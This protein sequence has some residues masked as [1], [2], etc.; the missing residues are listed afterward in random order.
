V[1]QSTY[2]C[3]FTKPI[4]VGKSII[5]L[6]RAGRKMRQMSYDYQ[7]DS[8]VSLDLTVFAEH[9][10]KDHDGAQQ[11]C[12]QQLPESAVYVRLG[13]GQI[14]VLTYEPDQ[15]VYAWTRFV[16]GGPDAFV[17]SIACVPE[18]SQFRLYM[19]VGRTINGS[20]VRTIEVLEPE[21][22][23]SSSTDR[24]EMYFFDNYT[25]FTTAPFTTS[26]TGLTLYAGCTVTVRVDDQI[27]H[28]QTV[29][30]DGT[31]TLPAVPSTR[32][33]IGFPYTSTLKTF[34]IE[35]PAQMGTG[36]GKVK[37]MTH[38]GVRLLDSIN[39]KHGS[40]LTN[41]V[42]ESFRLASDSVSAVPPMFSGDKRVAFE[43]GFSTRGAFYVV[44]EKAY[45][46]AILSLMPE[47][48][49]YS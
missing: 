17:E 4:N 28:D 47:I 8:Q 15:Q 38:L 19:V 34:P 13:D 48:A 24:T 25:V 45:P 29:A 9:I 11:L 21:F 43:N 26:L 36:Q 16:L 39:F 22:R 42:E 40:S 30:A 46:L 7:T 35:A 3:E 49:Q 6:Q 32:Y 37:R 44:Q 2:G 41:L 12:Y 27:Y 1:G 33:A 10:L 5:Y 14:A 23:P 18:G 31:M 20:W